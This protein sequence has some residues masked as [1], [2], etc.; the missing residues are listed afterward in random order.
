MFHFND[1]WAIIRRIVFAPV[2]VIGC[3]ATTGQLIAANTSQSVE[4]LDIVLQL[5][6]GLKTTKDQ[7]MVVMWLEDTNRRFVKTIYRFGKKDKK[8]YKDLPVSFGLYSKV[9]KSEDL[10]AVTGAT[11][12]W[13]SHGHIQLPARWRGLDLLSGKF[14]LRIESAKD[15]GQRFASF[16]I[17][18]KPQV[19]DNSFKDKG[20]VT[21]VKIKVAPP[22]MATKE[23]PV[24]I[25][26]PAGKPPRL[27]S[28]QIETATVI[29]TVISAL[30]PNKNKLPGVQVKIDATEEVVKFYP[31]ASSPETEDI[32]K[33]M[34]A[35][36]KGMKIQIEYTENKGSYA[37]KL[38][39]APH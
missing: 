34:S 24:M 15:H 26:D 12:I 7:P 36:K 39:A 6:N 31:R 2:A 9:E 25:P 17:P 5:A 30:P 27:P 13:G 4:A 22:E 38:E 33:R 23:N 10:D 37:I 19:L 35:C 14:V 11:I 3:T 28:G 1:H 8:H 29:A 20:Y 18:L 32:T 21:E 16:S